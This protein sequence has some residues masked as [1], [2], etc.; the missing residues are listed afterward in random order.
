MRGMRKILVVIAI[1]A[2]VGLLAPDAVADPLTDEAQFVELTNS[3]RAANGLGP[4]A[5]D[6]ALVESARRHSARMA[7]AGTIFH[8]SNL[9]NEFPGGGWS[10]LGENVGVGPTVDAIH[11]ALMDSPGH[12]A[13][14]LGNY[15]KVGMGVVVRDNAIFVTQVFW[16]SALPAPATVTGAVAPATVAA[17]NCRKVRRRTV[18]RRALRRRARRR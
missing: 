15:D 3:A 2:M 7:E 4:L 9:G 13:N 17:K 11:A 12:R 10:A 6:G 5:V 8:N 1:G 18:C 16:K 14:L